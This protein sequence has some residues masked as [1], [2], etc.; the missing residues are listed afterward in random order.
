MAQDIFQ[1]I[2]VAIERWLE[3]INILEE[4]LLKIQTLRERIHRTISQVEIEGQTS[5]MDVARLSHVGEM[6]VNL[7]ELLETSGDKR[8]IL[9]NLLKLFD[10][11]EISI[12]F[13]TE[14]ILKV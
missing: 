2:M 12:N 8:T 14:I 10:Y 6:W 13:V 4:R 3:D 9:M 1:D 5:T 11:G 7:L